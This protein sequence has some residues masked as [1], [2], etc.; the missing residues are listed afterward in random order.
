MGWPVI[1]R[2]KHVAVA[3]VGGGRAALI[4]YPKDNLTVILFTNLT[5]SSPEE[6]IEKIS[7]FYISD[8]DN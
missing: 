2:K 4:I 5:D 6:I 8:I 1:N 7:R 3:P